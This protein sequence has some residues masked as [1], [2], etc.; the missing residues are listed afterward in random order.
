MQT[1]ST[2]RERLGV[3]LV[4]LS[5]GL[6]ILGMMY[7]GRYRAHQQREAERAR[8]AAAAAVETTPS[9]P[10]SEVSGTP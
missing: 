4:G 10:A 9:D 8:E 1:T 2:F 6:M 7:M 3:Y 5:I